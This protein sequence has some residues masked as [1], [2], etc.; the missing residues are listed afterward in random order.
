[1]HLIGFTRSTTPISDLFHCQNGK[2][3]LVYVRE[4]SLAMANR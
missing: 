1:M 3:K 4:A 2:N